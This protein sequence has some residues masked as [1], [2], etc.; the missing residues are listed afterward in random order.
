MLRV[1]GGR[2]DAV[3]AAAVDGR[4]HGD[5]PLPPGE[6]SLPPWLSAG[7]STFVSTVLS[8]VASASL[9]AKVSSAGTSGSKAMSR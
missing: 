8:P 5:L 6:A 9:P 3:R 7:L 2:P 4:L 1:D